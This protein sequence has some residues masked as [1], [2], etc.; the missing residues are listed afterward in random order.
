MTGK[1][2]HALGT[3]GEPNVK[4]TNGKTPAKRPGSNTKTPAHK[5]RT[6]MHLSRAKKG[7]K[8]AKQQ[9]K[10]FWGQLLRGVPRS[11][12]T[13]TKKTKTGWFFLGSVLCGGVGPPTP[14]TQKNK[15][16]PYQQRS[17]R[18]EETITRT[19]VKKLPVSRRHGRSK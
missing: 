3:V 4:P 18:L 9:P 15:K 6:A 11:E 10:F 2:V 14:P 8:K 7:K 19:T 12:S 1:K 17:G 13:A 5:L 16:P